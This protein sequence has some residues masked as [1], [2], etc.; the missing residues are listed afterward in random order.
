VRGLHGARRGTLEKNLERRKIVWDLE[1][2]FQRG[3]SK[4]EMKI[5]LK[6]ADR[7]GFQSGRGGISP[8]VQKNKGG[9]EV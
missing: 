4:G 3:R 1:G 9:R 2:V 5:D 7:G 6:G 8:S